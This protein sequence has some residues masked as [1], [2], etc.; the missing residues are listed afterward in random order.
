MQSIKDVTMI[1]KCLF[2]VIT[3]VN[4]LQCAGFQISNRTRNPKTDFNAE[5]LKNW[6]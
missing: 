3:L 6:S 1:F 5:I 4:L 2:Y